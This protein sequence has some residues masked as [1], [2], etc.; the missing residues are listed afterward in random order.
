MADKI[1]LIV[2]LSMLGTGFAL[3]TQPENY[4][5]SGGPY[6]YIQPHYLSYNLTDQNYDPNFI[7][8]PNGYQNWLD[9]YQQGN[10]FNSIASRQLPIGGF[11]LGVIAAV[12][13]VRS[14]FYV[15]F[16]I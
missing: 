5:V 16:S 9:N 6:A 3:P 14:I 8:Y 12:A 2:L 10:H 1:C 4:Q 11:P 7:W 13:S 15:L